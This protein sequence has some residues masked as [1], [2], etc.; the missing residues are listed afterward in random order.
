MLCYGDVLLRRCFVQ[1]RFVEDIFVRGRFVCAS[2]LL[3]ATVLQ[4]PR[5]NTC[6]ASL[7]CGKFL[8]C[9]LKK[10]YLRRK[11]LQH[12]QQVFIHCGKEKHKGKIKETLLLGVVALCGRMQTS[13]HAGPCQESIAP[14]SPC[15]TPNTPFIPPH[16]HI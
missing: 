13:P 10:I 5:I 12:R 7:S 9:R 14:L 8:T 1:T 3:F 15:P 2:Y 11:H 16:P 6:F 4:G